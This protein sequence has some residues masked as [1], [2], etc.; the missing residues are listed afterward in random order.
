[1]TVLVFIACAAHFIATG[2]LLTVQITRYAPGGKSLLSPDLKTSN[3]E[4]LE[5]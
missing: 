4:K 5:G 3:L 1:M 2:I